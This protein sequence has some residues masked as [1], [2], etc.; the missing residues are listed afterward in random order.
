MIDD[1]MRLVGMSFA[2]MIKQLRLTRM[3]NQLHQTK[4]FRDN[5]T[6]LLS[7]GAKAKVPPKSNTKFYTG[8]I[9]FARCDPWHFCMQNLPTQAG[10]NADRDLAHVETQRLI[11]TRP[12]R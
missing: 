4:L 12:V 10:A 1:R 8:N 5:Q 3:I 2:G 7:V 6:P 9:R 11:L